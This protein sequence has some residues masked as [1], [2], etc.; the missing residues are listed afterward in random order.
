MRATKR[1][2]PTPGRFSWTFVAAT[3]VVINWIAPERV[4]K[5]ALPTLIHAL[6]DPR[7][8]IRERAAFALRHI[9][10]EPR[11]TV[12]AL[13]MALDDSTERVRGWAIIG[14]RQFKTDAAVAVSKL[15]ILL[16]TTT[17]ETQR[18]AAMALIDIDP[19]AA[20]ESGAYEIAGYSPPP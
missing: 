17:K 7:P 20:K 18:A 11:L 4:G 19:K 3:A 12:P 10:K 6:S 1:R 8:D 2:L 13:T 16:S 14:L 9:H 5:E 15:R